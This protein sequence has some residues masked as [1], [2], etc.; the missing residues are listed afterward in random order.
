MIARARCRKCGE[1]GRF[2]VGDV[3]T[4]AEA[5]GKLDSAHIRS[6]PFGHHVEMADILYEVLELQDGSAPTMDEWKAEMV[7]KGLDLWTTDE[8]RQTEITIE[9]FA[10]GMPM[11]KLRGEDFWLD[12]TTAPNGERYWYAPVGAYAEA[13][14]PG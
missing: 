12:F 11:A 1:V 3:A 5:Q 9:T 4:A 13:T 8:L 6:C 7:A 2:D 10:F 14:A